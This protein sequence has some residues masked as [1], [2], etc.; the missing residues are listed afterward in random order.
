[1]VCWVTRSPYCHVGIAWFGAKQNSKMEV[2]HF[3]EKG[4]QHDYLND[5]VLDYGEPDVYRIEGLTDNQEVS[6]YAFM[7]GLDFISSHYGFFHTVTTGIVRLM[8][9]WVGKLLDWECHRHAPHC[10]EAVC[11][12]FR[13]GADI[14]LV[15][16]KPDWQT[17]PGDIIKAGKVKRV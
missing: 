17:A 11:R 9:Q 6:I 10:S 3:T 1:M 5:V 8:P 12:A 14:D 2:I 15:P 4:G 13:Y 7:Y 16:N